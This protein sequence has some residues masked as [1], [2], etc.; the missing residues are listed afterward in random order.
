MRLDHEVT[1][2]LDDEEYNPKTHE[3]GEPKEVASAAA[4]VTDMGT[5]KSAQLFGNYAQKAKVIRLVEPITVNWSYLTIDDDATH[6]ALNTS[7]DPL[8][9]A[10][11][12]VG[13]TK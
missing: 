11:L 3:Y 9:N 13:E 2:W 4:S 5:D 7:R 8:Q 10:T 6:Y 12:I 1:F